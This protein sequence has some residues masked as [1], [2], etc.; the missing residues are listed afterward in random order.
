M[1][2]KV[3]ADNKFDGVTAGTRV[4]SKDEWRRVL[5]EWEDIVASGYGDYLDFQD[6]PLPD[7]EPLDKELIQT[8]VET[9]SAS[10][11]PE[12]AAM[13][14]GPIGPAELAAPLITPELVEPDADLE[15]AAAAD[16]LEAAEAEKVATDLRATNAAAADEVEKVV[17]DKR[18]AAAKKRAAKKGH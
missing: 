16:E 7:P 13:Q 17:A 15:A 3:K 5:P 14:S 9:V 12:P 11:A 1:Q 2:A 8:P 18:A 4:Y 6:D 10:P